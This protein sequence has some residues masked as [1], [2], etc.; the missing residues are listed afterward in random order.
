MRTPGEEDD[1]LVLAA[2]SG[3]RQAFALLYHRYK[4]DVWNLAYLTLR[5]HHEAEDSLQETFVK[6]LRALT[7]AS[8]I[9]SVRPWLLTICRNVCL[10]KLRAGRRRQ[11]ISL[12]EEDAPEPAAAPVD[13]EQR[14]DFHR[15]L[16]TLAPE[17]REAF[18]LVDVL[19]CRS[20]EAAEIAGLRAAST[21]RSRLGR[22]RSQIAGVVAEQTG[23]AYAHVHAEIWGVYHHP[24]DSAIV[25]SFAA[26]GAQAQAQDRLAELVACLE[27]HAAHSGESRNGFPLVEFLER[28]DFRIPSEHRVI[29]VIDDRPPHTVTATQHWF[30]D[31]P[32]WQVRRPTSH[33]SWLLEVQNLLRAAGGQPPTAALAALQA[34]E[35][36]VW[37]PG[38]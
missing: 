28:L 22:A 21:L 33:A 18:V 24:P 38:S 35:P 29:A 1:A 6:A 34:T 14:I 11:V 10:D 9:E 30:A 7:P 2:R 23:A 16:E 5:N 19:G 20:H 31:H 32:R 37:S 15:A 12:A 26:V 8:D 3:D 13:H 25:A 27:R 4:L 17:D 36:F